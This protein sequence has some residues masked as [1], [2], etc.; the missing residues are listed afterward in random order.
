ML[1]VFVHLFSTQ[2]ALLNFQTALAVMLWILSFAPLVICF[3]QYLCITAQQGNL[4]STFH[5]IH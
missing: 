1:P 3:L 5:N 4:S 2:A